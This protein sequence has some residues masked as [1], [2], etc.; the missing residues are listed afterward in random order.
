MWSKNGE[1][2]ALPPV[3]LSWESSIVL[4]W[5]CVI[6]NW[7][8]NICTEQLGRQIL[9]YLTDIMG[10]QDEANVFLNV[11]ENMGEMTRADRPEGPFRWRCSM[12]SLKRF[13]MEM[14]ISQKMSA[15]RVISVRTRKDSVYVT[16]C[17]LWTDAN[18]K[19][20]MSPKAWHNLSP[21]ELS[22][23]RRHYSKLF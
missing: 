17:H 16:W 19:L 6:T 8:R 5:H 20:D 21:L 7:S 2:S 18:P 10:S 23:K 9:N 14:Q 3:W 1:T 15:W 12:N 4:F 11:I 22:C 13:W